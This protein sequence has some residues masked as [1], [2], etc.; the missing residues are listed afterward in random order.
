VMDCDSFDLVVNLVS[1]G[2][3]VSIVPHRA[4]ALHP[5]T[6]P[7]RRILVKPKFTRQLM[8]VRRKQKEGVKIVKDFCDAVLF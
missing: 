8:A 1:L 3:G 5:Q 2:F 7:V 6:R 4:L